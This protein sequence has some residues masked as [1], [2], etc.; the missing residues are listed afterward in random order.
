MGVYKEPSISKNQIEE[1]YASCIVEPCFFWCQYANAEELDKVSKLS[2]EAVQTQLDITF[3]K[4]L[5]PGSPCLALFSTDN[6]WYRALVMERLDDAFHVVF[7]DYGNETDVAVKNVR[8]LPESLLDMAPQAFLC[9][10]N[11]FSDS[12]GSWD[13]EFKSQHFHI[14]YNIIFKFDDYGSYKAT[15][16]CTNYL[17]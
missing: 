14:F 11:G 12:K 10:L 13:D 17:G 6:Q 4:T 2:Q 15:S 5:G 8:P 7:I 16:A 9:S 3:P 1:V